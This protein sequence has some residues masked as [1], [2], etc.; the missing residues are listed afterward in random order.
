[1]KDKSLSSRPSVHCEPHL[2]EAPH[3][4]DPSE[5]TAAEI[6]AREA[7]GLA[8]HEHGVWE[9]PALSARLSGGPG[10][11]QI[12]YARWLEGKHRSTPPWQTWLATLMI[13]LLA[14]P[15]AV[16]GALWGVRAGL[17]GVIAVVVLGPLM[18]EVLKVAAALALVERRPY[19]FRSGQQILLT[20][21]AAGLAFAAIENVLYL[22]VYVPDASAALAHWR[23]TVCVALHTGCSL[24][25]GLGVVAV[26]RHAN[27]HLCKPQARLAFP[28]IATAATI[29]GLYNGLATALQSFGPPVW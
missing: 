11:E 6:L 1:M 8:P 16:L 13:I 18:E 17:F 22:T 14:G 26:W 2:S 20:A 10:P 21:A 27:R 28:Y 4:A 12:T 3:P 15:W 25:A 9:E 5:A 23:W 24:V 7:D 29:H 19:L